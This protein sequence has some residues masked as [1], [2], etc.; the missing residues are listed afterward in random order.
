MPYFP[1]LTAPGCTGRTTVFNFP[2]NNWEKQSKNKKFV[3]LTWQHG[4]KWKTVVIDEIQ[5]GEFK[6]YDEST[7]VSYTSSS[8]LALLSLSNTVFPSTSLSLPPSNLYFE[9]P[10]WRASLELL[11]LSTSTSTSYQGEVDPFPSSGSLLSFSPF[12]QPKPLVRNYLLFLNLE[13]FPAIRS[14][15][16]Q[17]FRST[18]FDEPV[19]VSSVFSNSITCVSL[20]NLGFQSD[21][22]VIISSKE[23]SGIPLFLTVSDD[24][25]FMSLEHTHPPASYVIHGNR[26][27]AQKHLKNRWFNNLNLS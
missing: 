9:V 17:I 2:P 19:L 21:D 22:L 15:N 18:H 26:W 24:Y 8:N 1:L 12:F 20:D 11:S 13:C 5:Y 10:T 23:I 14:A 4:S 27:A 25:S 3:N 7:L 6:V 16:I